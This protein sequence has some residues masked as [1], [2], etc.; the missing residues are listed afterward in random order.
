MNPRSLNVSVIVPAFNEE[1]N[2]GECLKHLTNQEEPADEIIVVNN[3]SIDGTVRI[4]KKFPV[5]IVNEST[6]GMIP[7]RNRGFNEAQY[8][9]IARTDAD[10]HV[11][12]DWI[13]H[14]KQI[15]ENNPDVIATSGPATFYDFPP[16]VRTSTLFTRWYIEMIEEKAIRHDSMF[17][18]NMAI[19]KAS[20]EKVKDEVCLN[21]KD[22]HE[23]IDLA[24]HLG[25]IGRI[26]FDPTLVVAASARRWKKLSPY[27]EQSYRS[28]KTIRRHN[29]TVLEMRGRQLVKG[30]LRRRKTLIRHLKQ[31]PEYL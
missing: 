20:W 15:F 31:L 24:I 10:T 16:P 23:D 12:P 9:I 5:R 21:D 28:I 27:F 19:R 6:Q 17:G 18:P 13:K 22:V 11:P 8:E 4:A 1:K 25:H 2:I 7:A 3:N 14:I 29:K 30:V 26:F